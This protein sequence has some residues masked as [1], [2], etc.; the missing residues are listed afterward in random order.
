MHLHSQ[1]QGKLRWDEDLAAFVPATVV[2][3]RRT[4]GSG[5]GSFD[6]ADCLAEGTSAGAAAAVAAGFESATQPT[7]LGEPKA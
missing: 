3:D 4:I 7:A 1:R 6:L 2:P 5:R